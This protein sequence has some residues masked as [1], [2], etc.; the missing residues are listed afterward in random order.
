MGN[1]ISEQLTVSNNQKDLS[2]KQI[3]ERI[4]KM[5]G[6][7]HQKPDEWTLDS[8]GTL[9]MG[10]VT[11]IKSNY[12]N[13]DHQQGDNVSK[14]FNQVE[15][16]GGQRHS[17]QKNRYLQ[18][19]PDT[20]ISKIQTGGD[21]SDL[22]NNESSIS[23]SYE[24]LSEFSAINDLKNEIKRNL[25]QSG[26]FIDIYTQDVQTSDQY[27]PTSPDL[28]PLDGG[29]RKKRYRGTNPLMNIPALPPNVNTPEFMTND[30]LYISDSVTTLDDDIDNIF[31]D[32]AKDED[33][34]FADDLEEAMKSDEDELAEMNEMNKINDNVDFESPSI[35]TSVMSGGS[36]DQVSA[37][38]ENETEIEMLPY[39]RTEESSN[40]DFKH[41]YL[42]NKFD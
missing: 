5:M 3:E 17:N 15:Q 9:D 13:F 31:D 18:Y 40:Y 36:S 19:N 35:E 8:Y 28:S 21:I 34:E 16:L 22:I 10:N 20:I 1:I 32:I 37:S 42:R 33:Q 24:E 14:M 39:Y 29:K 6:N 30:K 38:S 11:P 27:S 2:N 26:G 23:E 12:A 25:D 4:R 7:T 41:P